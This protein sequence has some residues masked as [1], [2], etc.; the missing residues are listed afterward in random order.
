MNEKRRLPASLGV[1]APLWA[2]LLK[3]RALPSAEAPPCPTSPQPPSPSVCPEARHPALP[4]PNQD[5]LSWP[6]ADNLICTFLMS[7][8]KNIMILLPSFSP[9]PAYLPFF[10]WHRAHQAF[11][12][13]P[14]TAPAKAVLPSLPPQAGSEAQDRARMRESPALT[15]T[16]ETRGLVQDP[17]FTNGLPCKSHLTS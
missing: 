14:T 3:G 12:Q 13:A 6:V 10:T 17:I 7:K 4:V 8:R 5:R 16:Q 11:V 2:E 1:A 9:L 15:C